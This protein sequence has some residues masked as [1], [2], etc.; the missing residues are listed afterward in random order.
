MK[1]FKGVISFILAAALIFGCTSVFASAYSDE[2]ITTWDDVYH[3]VGKMTPGENT[4]T[5]NTDYS[6]DYFSFNAENEGYYVFSYNGESEIYGVCHLYKNYSSHYEE[7][8]G[9]VNADTANLI[10]LESGENLIGVWYNGESEKSEKIK[11]EYAGR[12]MTD[13]NFDAGTE[14]PIILCCDVTDDGHEYMRICGFSFTFDSEKTIDFPGVTEYFEYYAPEGIKAGENEVKLIVE[15]KEFPK[16]LKAAH[17]RDYIEKVELADGGISEVVYY[18]GSVMGTG[19]LEFRITYT[20]GTVIT[21]G[22]YD[23]I[24]LRNGS[25]DKYTLYCD[26]YNGK[27]LVQIGTN[28]MLEFTYESREA[29]FSENL[30]VFFSDIKYEFNYISRIPAKAEELLE[31]DSAADTLREFGEFVS[32]VNNNFFYAIGDIFENL[33]LLFATIS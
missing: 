4:V 12:E 33:V 20:D 22:E 18:N 26:Y 28:D 25:P 14:Y 21:A 3:Y 19:S 24:S 23:E 16:T 32:F 15:E 5:S 9:A 13:F 11:V 29:S 7:I 10:Y 17:I 30:S 6:G 2:I 1:K 31:Q 8:W 27:G